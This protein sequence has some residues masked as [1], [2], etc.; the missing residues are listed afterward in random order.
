MVLKHILDAQIFDYD[1]VCRIYQFPGYLMQELL[2]K[3]S[4]PLCDFGQPGLGFLPVIGTEL[5]AVQRFISSSIHL[6]SLDIVLWIVE[7]LTIRSYGDM[8]YAKVHSDRCLGLWR[9]WI[10]KL[11]RKYDIPCSCL[12]SLFPA[13]RPIVLLVACLGIAG[14]CRRFSC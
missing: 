4:Y 1:S 9:G 3:V 2:A 8:S 11:S 13:L 7:V 12:I 6:L 10:L 5:L 14:T